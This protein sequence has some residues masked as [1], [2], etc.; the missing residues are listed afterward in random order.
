[1]VIQGKMT[2][3][4]FLS[5]NYLNLRQSLIWLALVTTAIGIVLW[6]LF[7]STKPAYGFIFIAVILIACISVP[8]SLKRNFRQYKALSEPFLVEIKDDGLYFTRTNGNGLIPW[9]EIVK[10]RCNKQAVLIYPAKNL[11]HIIP[12]HFFSSNS[13]F[14]EFISLLINKLGKAT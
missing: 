2:E 10:W 3:Q 13:E 8:F 4:D 9:G 11:F 14:E 12:S 1:M 5:A 6:Y 7:T